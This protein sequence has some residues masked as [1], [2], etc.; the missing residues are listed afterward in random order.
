MATLRKHHQSVVVGY[1]P[2]SQLRLGEKFY[3]VE[4]EQ[5]VGHRRTV[6]CVTHKGSLTTVLCLDGGSLTCSTKYTNV[7]LVQDR[8]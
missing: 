7:A 8:E 5:L 3:R 4:G 2:L 6:A 1:K